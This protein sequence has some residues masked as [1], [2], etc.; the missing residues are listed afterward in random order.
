M[1]RHFLIIFALSGLLVY[2]L[3]CPDNMYQ[4]GSLCCKYCPV[5]TYMT[6]T[7]NVSK[8]NS[9]CESCP[10]ETFM[11]KQNN[12]SKCKQC[13]KCPPSQTAIRHC[14]P[15][16]DRECRCPPGTY[17]DKE[18]LICLECLKCNVGYGAVSPC[19]NISNTECQPCREGTFS[20]RVSHE[21]EC[22]NCSQCDPG[23]VIK[24][25]CIATRDTICQ[26]ANN[27]R[28]STVSQVVTS[29][30]RAPSAPTNAGR[31]LSPVEKVTS[32]SIRY[33]IGI[34]VTVVLLVL[35]VV[36]IYCYWRKQNRHEGNQAH[37]PQEME[38]AKYDFVPPTSSETPAHARSS[39]GLR[40]RRT[41]YSTRPNSHQRD[42][43]SQGSSGSLQGV[44]VS[45]GKSKTLVRDL[46]AHVFIEL[47]KFLNPKS[48][49]NWVTLAGYLEFTTNEIKNFE[50]EVNEATQNVLYQWGQKDSSTVDFLINVL[51]KMKRDDCV[52]VLKPWD[53]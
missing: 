51:K 30:S 28:I 31:S 41:V 4:S 49:K 22:L 12:N 53:N 8:G 40:G 23:A 43:D 46:P 11:D 37:N 44:S 35:I 36:A 38:E 47:G 20:D 10:S 32:N 39:Y 1:E 19:T 13:Q 18:V 52:Q 26:R 3:D 27:S 21:Q 7:C 25:E 50:L 24:E 29:V 9:F 2:A 14:K 6:K 33:I 48:S 34:V 15:I 16:H 45:N 17:H 42:S 5:G